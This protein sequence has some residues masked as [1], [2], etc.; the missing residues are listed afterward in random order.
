ML[1]VSIFV[2]NGIKLRFSLIQEYVMLPIHGDLL[3]AFPYLIYF[4]H[5]A[6]KPA[7]RVI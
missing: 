6:C 3:S 5:V 1:G 2:R 7:L 4:A